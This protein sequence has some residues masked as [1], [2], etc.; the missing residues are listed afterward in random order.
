MNC[1]AYLWNKFFAMMVVLISLLF[2]LQLFAQAKVEKLFSMS[3]EEL[4]NVK[5]YSATKTHK[6]IGEA[7]SIITVITTAEIE[8]MGARTLSDVLKMTAGIQILNRRNGRDMVWMRGVTT[9][10]NTKVLLLIDGVPQREVVFGEWSPDEEILLNNIDRIEIIKGPGSALYGANAYAGVISIF[11][12]DNVNESRVSIARG[13][14]DSYRVQFYSG[15]EKEGAKIILA[16]NLYET[17]GHEM[18]RDRKGYET[19]HKD[20][21]EAR[22]FHSKFIYKDFRIAYTQ[23][24]FT[25]SYPLYAEGREKPQHFTINHG[26]ADFIFNSNNVTFTPKIYFYHTKHY[27]DNRAFDEAGELDNMGERHTKSHLAGF[28]IQSTIQLSDNNTLVAGVTGEHHRVIKYKES[29]LFKT[30][31]NDYSYNE[32]S[33]NGDD[34]PIANNY[35]I[36]IQDDMRFF[37]EKLGITAGLRYDKY[38]GF[39]AQF[40]PRLGFTHTPTDRFFLKGLLG[41]AFKPPTFRQM[42]QIRNDGKSPG[43]PNVDSE[44]ISTIEAEAGYYI[45][46]NIL[47]RISVFHNELTDFIESVAYASYSNSEDKIKINGGALDIKADFIPY[48]DYLKTISVFGN[49]CFAD[50][51]YL[52]DSE[53]IDVPSV[54]K[55]SGN[56]GITLR[57]NYITLFSG[58]NIIGKR[59]ESETYHSSVKAPEYKSKDNK[60][61]YVIWDINLGLHHF[62]KM[63]LQLDLTIRNLLN[64]E[65]FNPTYDPDSYYDYTKESRFIKATVTVKL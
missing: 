37:E 55:H 63:P 53:K 3:I 26:F 36:Y 47:A 9:G 15:A 14:F 19:N 62:C 6:K 4:M 50:T 18:E 48:L 11:T 10:Y 1:Q 58:W 38:E 46:N 44:K 30:G 35:G 65:H 27:F 49:Y 60:G 20:Y 61:S 39:D 64:V 34:T 29:V 22:N 33:K 8:E 13:S 42:Y 56:I 45:F 28:D 2:P 24:R 17:D 12:K 40:S 31:T 25:T 54:A 59:N 23:N 7:P 51:K 43:N 32:L 16:G 5:V 41:Y 21:V 52:Q 57:N